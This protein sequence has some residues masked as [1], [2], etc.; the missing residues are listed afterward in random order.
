MVDYITKKIQKAKELDLTNPENL[1]EGIY[2]ATLLSMFLAERTNI[3]TK[4]NAKDLLPYLNYFQDTFRSG[5]IG[6]QRRYKK[7]FKEFSTKTAKIINDSKL[8]HDNFT[9]KSRMRFE[10]YLRSYLEFISKTLEYNVVQQDIC[11]LASAIVMSQET[12]AIENQYKEHVENITIPRI[13]EEADDIRS[14]HH[15][16]MT[17]LATTKT[18]IEYD[19]PDYAFFMVGVEQ[20]SREKM[21]NLIESAKDGK[22]DLVDAI[23]AIYQINNLIQAHCDDEKDRLFIK[24]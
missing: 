5:N 2:L 13:K 22:I 23:T 14:Y 7:V 6:E 15:P 1:S 4:D 11:Q 16:N 12:S 3:F 19:S 9:I 17:L 8:K 10:N 24:I 20:Y 21:L 18:D